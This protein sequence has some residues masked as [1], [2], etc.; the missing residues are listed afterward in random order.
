MSEEIMRSIINY[1]TARAASYSELNREELGWGMCER[2]LSS[3]ESQFPDKP[4]EE[5]RVLDIGTGPGFMA[6]L[7]AQAGYSPDAVD[8]TAGMLAEAKKNASEYSDRIRFHLMN[9]D[10]LDFADATFDVIVSRNLTWNLPDPCI[11][12]AEWLRVLKP[13][14]RVVIFDAN[15]YRYLFDDDARMEYDRDRD[16]VAREALR[17]FNLVPNFEVMEDIARSLPMS[18]KH[19][20]YWDRDKMLETGYR[21]VDICEDIW[22]EVWTAEEK[23]N[24]A[25]TPM[26]RIT[27]IK[28]T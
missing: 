13:G 28:R 9:A 5:M 19:R 25:S 26:F 16:E 7:L 11:C 15:W 12:Y 21:H 23:T 3:M 4:K 18:K 8:C 20:P 22:K 27:G 1:W 17:D 2:W 14:G 10:A 24:Y 6:I